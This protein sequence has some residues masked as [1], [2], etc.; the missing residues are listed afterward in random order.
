VYGTSVWDVRLAGAAQVGLRI[1]PEGEAITVDDL[2]IAQFVYLLLNNAKLRSV[3]DTL[4]AKTVLI[5]GRFTPERKAVLDAMRDALGKRDL[6]PIVYDFDGPGSRDITETVRTLAHL[7]RFIIADLTDPRSVPQELMAV[8]PTLPSVPVQPIIQ[9]DQEPWSMFADLRRYP[10]VLVPY[11]YASAE[12][13]IDAFDAY[14][15][16]PAEAAVQRQRPSQWASEG[17]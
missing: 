11:R 13:L 10:W 14:V 6:V 16:I 17:T 3:I 5:L 4:T 2:E 12:S 7:S 1:T 9:A 8:V 15:L